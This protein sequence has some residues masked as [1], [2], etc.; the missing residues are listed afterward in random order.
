MTNWSRM[1]A[2]AERAPHQT[3]AGL[4]YASATQPRPRAARCRREARTHLIQDDLGTAAGARRA[5]A[6][7]AELVPDLDP[8][9]H[10]VAQP[11]GGRLLDL[12][13]ARVAA[14][15]EANGTS[16]L[17]LVQAAQP[18]PRSGSSVIYLSSTCRAGGARSSFP[19]TARREPQKPSAS[20]LSATSPPN[21]LPTASAST[22]SSL[23]PS[24]PRPSGQSSAIRPTI[25]HGSAPRAVPCQ[26]SRSAI[27]SRT[28]S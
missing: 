24:T 9:V 21:W 7:A 5:M 1:T 17:Y 10:C 14:A 18:L 11:I 20:A 26:I 6:A 8:L 3:A 16:L 22:R 19:G 28:T 27:R 25:W 13:P 23:A 12:D 15:I 2:E 4:W